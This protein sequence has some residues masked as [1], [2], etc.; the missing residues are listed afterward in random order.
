MELLTVKYF[1]LAI[2]I[3]LDNQG[4]DLDIIDEG[5]I[6]LSIKDATILN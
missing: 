1:D 6:N 2:S 3:F 5:I 4:I